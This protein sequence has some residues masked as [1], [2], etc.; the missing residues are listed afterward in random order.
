MNLSLEYGI[1]LFSAVITLLLLIF[2]VNWRY[3]RDWV[4]VFFFKS[5]LDLIGGSYVVEAHLIKYPVR[6][7]SSLYDTSLLF[8]IW[9]FPVLCILY[10]QATRERGMWPIIYYAFLFSA[11]ITVIEVSL[12]VYT[13]LIE[14]I[15]WHWYTTFFSLTVAFLISRAFLGFFRWGCDYFS[16][17]PFR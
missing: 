5:F 16:F 12:E 11:G 1:M 7:F 3:F 6:F 2:A 9:V 14:Y 10:N 4:T 15:N 17:R 8:E 13:E